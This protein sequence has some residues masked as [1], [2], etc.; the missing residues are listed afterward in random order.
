MSM[1]VNTICAR[2][3]ETPA[4]AQW[5]GSP[6]RGE[7]PF[8]V[9][10]AAPGPGR[11]SWSFG[12]GGEETGEGVAHT[13]PKPGVY[14][15]KA[16]RGDTT[17]VRRVMVRAAAPP[18]LLAALPVDSRSLLLVFDEPVAADGMRASADGLEL[19][20]TARH[21]DGREV[22]VKSDRPLA[23][24]VTVVCRNVADLATLPNVAPELKASASVPFWPR[25]AGAAAFLWS[26]EAERN[27]VYAGGEV[28]RLD[29]NLADAHWGLAGFDGL[30]RIRVS[31]GLLAVTEP[32]L[33]RRIT[34]ICAAAEAL[35]V[36]V[37]VTSDGPCEA[38][39]LGSFGHDG[40]NLA[41]RQSGERLV[42]DLGTSAGRYTL[43][44]AE[45]ASGR[46]THLV[47]VLSRGAL[48]CYEDG[49]QTLGSAGIWEGDFSRWTAGRLMFVGA[50][51]E[52]AGLV[53]GNDPVRGSQWRGT[54]ERVALFGRALSGEEIGIHWA[55]LALARTREAIPRAAVRAVLTQRTATPSADDLGPYRDALIA[56]TYR[57][58][59]VEESA[60][61]ERLKAGEEIVVH[62]WFYRGR[63]IVCD[64]ERPVG[65][66]RRLVIEPFDAHGELVGRK[67][68]EELDAWDARAFYEPF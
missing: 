44:L 5:A 65:G 3:G 36:E 37:L 64:D 9:R 31:E 35:S 30:G 22:M 51:M 40:P 13:F 55:S 14:E 63:E 7:A 66:R 59:E 4:P 34:E 26:S 24:P 48:A 2:G 56:D 29:V 53:V 23:G 27:F 18:R 68:F 21:G 19:G 17:H 25:D 67:S 58:E 54:I 57:V 33:V 61:A 39:V 47:V 8:S 42:L 62:R 11:W 60:L 20:V 32:G 10:L 50:P 38:T 41:L 52:P 46:P 28:G 49:S 15:V 43:P 12:D 1:M 45:L 6:I 16:T